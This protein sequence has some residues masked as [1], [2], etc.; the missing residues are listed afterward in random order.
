[1][2]KDGHYQRRFDQSGM[3][4]IPRE[5][6]HELEITDCSDVEMDIYIDENRIVLEKMN[7]N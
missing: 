4:H 3:I 6:R 5:I 7:K 2:S 1:M